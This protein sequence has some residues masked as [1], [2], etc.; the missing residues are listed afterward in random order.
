VVVPLKPEDLEDYVLAYGEQ[1][2]RDRLEADRE[3]A[4]GETHALDDVVAELDD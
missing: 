1:F 3:L 2:V 4:A